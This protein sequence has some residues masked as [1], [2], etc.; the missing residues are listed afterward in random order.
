MKIK[1]LKGVAFALLILMVDI[2]LFGFDVIPDILGYLLLF[3]FLGT[4]A[5]DE[6][7][8][9]P[10]RAVGSLL[11]LHQIVIL[12]N[13][14]EKGDFL[15]LFIIAGYFLDALM[16]YYIFRG[17]TALS[18]THDKR[19]LLKTIDRSFYFYAPTVIL[20]LLPEL[21]PELAKLCFFICICL[22]L[23]VLNT[24]ILCYNTILLPVPIDEDTEELEAV[25]VDGTTIMR[26]KHAESEEH[27][28]N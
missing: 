27:S 18:I 21:A 3:I 4:L 24:I 11:F 6:P 9:A 16:V 8:F 2:P 17:L 20:I 19:D 13:L 25:S 1:Q 12:F 10:A 7:R 5:V 22:Y 23:Y 15:I 26:H 14:L 28:E